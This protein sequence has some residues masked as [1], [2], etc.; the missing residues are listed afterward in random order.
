MG[1]KFETKI[2]EARIRIQG[3]VVIENPVMIASSEIAS[4]VLRGATV[5][6]ARR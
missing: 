5:T 4:A 1:L 6:G 2:D 3:G